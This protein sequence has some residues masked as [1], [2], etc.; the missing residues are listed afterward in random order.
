MSDSCCKALTVGS[1]GV[2]QVHRGSTSHRI[3]RVH[4]GDGAPDVKL[5]FGDSLACSLS[6]LEVARLSIKKSFVLYCSLNRGFGSFKNGLFSL[7]MFKLYQ[8]FVSI[9]LLMVRNFLMLPTNTWL[10]TTRSL[11][12][13]IDEC[14][15]LYKCPFNTCAINA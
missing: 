11:H 12:V 13:V 7:K 4:E 15:P 9:N 10:T 5:N 3:D 1:S 2:E 6:L 14:V 8:F